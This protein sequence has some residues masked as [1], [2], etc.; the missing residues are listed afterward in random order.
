M[1]L[2]QFKRTGPLT[3]FLIVVIL[4]SLWTGAFIRQRGQFSLYFDLDPM[5]FYGLLSELTGT[6]PIPGIISSLIIVGL[7]AFLMV[8]LNTVLFFINER[9]FIPALFYILLSG[10]LPQYQLLNPAIIAAVFLML[11]IRRIME[12][13]RI[14]GTAY[15]FF[16]AGILIATG[17]LFYANL[18][19]FGLILIAGIALLRPW[20]LKEV[21]LS[22]L[23]LLTPYLLTLGFYY[24][25]GADIAGF[26][27]LMNYNLFGMQAQF[28]FS[29]LIIVGLILTGLLTAAGIAHL[30]AMINSKKIQ[31]RKTFTLLLWVFIISMVIYLIIPAVS[32]EIIW[33]T[34]IPV[35]YFLSHYFLFLR[36]KLLAEILFTLFLVLILAIQL[37]SL[38]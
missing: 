35:S 21:V 1:L 22:V 20:N 23:G 7:M 6:H 31:S 38:L 4:V 10:L 12:S 5:P 27:R 9:S 17:S 29:P 24:V 14:Q 18:I 2:R 26:L 37:F 32:V 8:N 16:D 34:A 19:W 33:I 11:A 28:A 13:Y 36:R 15:N 30:F 3:I 25:A